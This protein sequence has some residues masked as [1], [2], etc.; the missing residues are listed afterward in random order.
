ML[1][2]NKY[3]IIAGIL[4]TLGAI[5]H[6][7]MIIGGPDWY[8]FFG[9]G[10]GM[11]QMAEKGM[12]YPAIAA[13][14]IAIVLFVWAAYAF[15]GAGVIKRLPLLKTGLVVIS[16][17]FIIRALFGIAV[18]NYIDHPYY[19]ELQARPTFMVVTSLICFI[20]GLFYIVGTFKNWNVLSEKS[21]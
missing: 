14:S 16:I 7:G 19:N 20:Y 4:S 12:A 10:E 8:R 1:S 5:L 21:T 11:A 9:A 6:L 3:L 2:N 13:A 17:I 15:S 18:V